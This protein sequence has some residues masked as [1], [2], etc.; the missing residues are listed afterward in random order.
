MRTRSP[1][2]PVAQRARRAC[3]V[4]LIGV[5][6]AVAPVAAATSQ[7]ARPRALALPTSGTWDP[8]FAAPGAVQ[9]NAGG[10]ASM[11]AISCT[12][13]GD[14]SAGGNYLDGST[15]QQGLTATEVNGTWQAAQPIPGLAALNAGGQVFVEAIS[16]SSP[17]NCV[18]GGQY[19]TATAGLNSFEVFV[20][21]QHNGT[22][23]D[24]I[25]LPNIITLD[26]GGNATLTSIS[27]ASEGA[28]SA[29]GYY[30]DTSSNSQVWVATQVAG[31]WG[32][33]EE[34]PGTGTLNANG[35]AQLTSMSCPTASTCE[36]VGFYTDATNAQQGFVETMV[37]GT[38]QDAIELPGLDTLNAGGGAQALSIS[39]AV[40]GD[41]VAGGYYTDATKGLQAFVS[42]E[43]TSTWNTAVELNGSAALNPGG[44][45]A[46][47]S[48][49][50]VAVQTC[51]VVGY[52]TD[53]NP[54]QQAMVD[55][56]VNDV[57]G[58]ASTPSGSAAL[59]VGG[60]AQLNA[61]SCTTI[62]SCVAV[63]FYQDVNTHS[64]AL[65]LQESGG[66]WGAAQTA[67]GS[68][69][70]NV[71]GNA[72]LTDL[73]CAPEGTCS[74]AGS[75]IAAASASEP[76]LEDFTP[77][78]TA[79]STTSPRASLAALAGGI[80]T[81]DTAHQ[82][83]VEL[84]E[85]DGTTVRTVSV[86]GATE[87]ASDGAHLW[88][89]SRSAGTLTEVASTGAVL[90]RVH[91][92]SGPT[93]VAYAA[94]KLTVTDATSSQV[95]VVTAANGATR[96][97]K[98]T[99]RPL[100]AAAV[101]PST[102]VLVAGNKLL[103][104]ATASGRLVRTVAV[105]AGAARVT[106]TAAALYVTS[107]TAGTVSVVTPSSGH[108][109]VIRNVGAGAFKAVVVGPYLFVTATRAG[110]V[111][112]VLSASGAVQRTVTGVTGASGAVVDAG[113][114]YVGCATAPAV[115]KVPTFS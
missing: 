42:E 32:N 70:L 91:L 112:V 61:V 31:A 78:A 44:G 103:A 40:P 73:S 19:H 1:M 110:R 50:C 8:A 87:V 47:Q 65:V 39:C 66:T 93:T 85:A 80:W 98:V 28:C 6:G 77:P 113:Y 17:G 29:G 96:S 92:P 56:E 26:N 84:R 30:T 75:F 7:S 23:G 107:A 34:A 102:F 63:G 41:C 27:C 105:G 38:W 83:L 69:A 109:R 104:Y 60:T 62:T 48:V 55:S 10:T 76:L 59:N 111:T 36:A 54:T 74:A 46:V 114:L 57:W 24:A 35:N 106:A 20:A 15:N 9:L 86:P 95:S 72:S 52:T 58:A 5:L 3:I 18:V 45:A 97:F 88:V 51:S 67:P 94:G 108:L 21:A 79:L 99:A 89:T 90:R 12:G 100:D 43:T 13:P 4:A 22:W 81:V 14:C 53:G 33:A 37:S 64:Q 49:D 101:G 11:T 16:C 25:A 71:G 82:R 2:H 115:V 68:L